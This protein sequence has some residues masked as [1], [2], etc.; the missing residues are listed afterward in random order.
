MNDLVMVYFS[1]CLLSLVIQCVHVAGSDSR[2]HF[3][4]ILL[5]C[6]SAD[7][8]TGGGAHEDK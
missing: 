2:L 8:K 7:V 3:R 4:V 6:G 1:T 5:M